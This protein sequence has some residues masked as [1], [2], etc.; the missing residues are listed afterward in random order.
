MKIAFAFPYGQIEAPFFMSVVGML[1]NELNT[2]DD[3]KLLGSFFPTG[4]CYISLNRNKSCARFLTQ[5]CTD[6]YILFIDTDIEFSPT[7]LYDFQEILA[8][9]PEAEIISGRVNIGNGFPVFY[10][11]SDH[12]FHEQYVQPFKGLREFT[13]V[14]TGIILL[15][16]K[17]LTVMY[18]KYGMNLFTHLVIPDNSLGQQVPREVGDDFSFCERAKDCGFKIFGSWSITGLHYKLQPIISRYPNSFDE[19]IVK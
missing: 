4:G 2:P 12:G 17:A 7:I 9:N 13:R 10:Q 15:S 6:D 1:L 14:G 8:L 19:V 16:R 11:A 5:P 18:T 3:M